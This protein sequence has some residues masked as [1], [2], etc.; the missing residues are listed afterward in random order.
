MVGNMYQGLEP[1]F[2]SDHLERLLRLVSHFQ[3]TIALLFEQQSQT[4]P[5]G[6]CD[7]AHLFRRFNRL[8]LVLL[9]GSVVLGRFRQFEGLWRALLFGIVVLSLLSRFDGLRLVIINEVFQDRVIVE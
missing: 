7:T 5:K 1:C 6:F 4:F 9:L 3:R 2:L 8:W